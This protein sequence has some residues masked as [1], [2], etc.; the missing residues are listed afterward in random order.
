MPGHS[1]DLC[2]H[3]PSG[4]VTVILHEPGARIPCADWGKICWN[5]LRGVRLWPQSPQSRREWQHTLA[6]LTHERQD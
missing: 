5:C 1:C 6:A 3:A 2:G 4:G